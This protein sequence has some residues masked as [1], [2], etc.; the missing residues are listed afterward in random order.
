MKKLKTYSFYLYEYLKHG[1]FASVW[2]SVKYLLV[3]RSHQHDRIIQSSIG[4]FYCRKGTNDFQFANYRYEWSLKRFIYQNLHDFTVFIDGGANVGHYTLLFAKKGI[5]VFA[6]E[7]IAQ[8]VEVLRK[9]IELNH[10]QEKVKVFEC[11]VGDTNRTAEFIFDPI[12]TGA[13]HISRTPNQGNCTV[14]LRTIDSMLQEFGLNENEK[15]LFK[16][17]VEGMEEEAIRGAKEFIRKYPNITFILEDKHTWRKAIEESM[18]AIAPFKFGV[19]DPFNMYAEK[20]SN[21]SKK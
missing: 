17:D 10:L 14:T 5:P 15:I 19:V 20:I 1:D 2:S 3:K 7:P 21:K 6:I 13:S 11:G 8:N 18:V 4:L 16:L 12:N 9:N